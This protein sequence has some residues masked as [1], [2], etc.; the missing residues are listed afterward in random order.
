M[1]RGEGVKRQARSSSGDRLAVFYFTT[2]AV[3]RI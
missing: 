1:G 2:G 3:K